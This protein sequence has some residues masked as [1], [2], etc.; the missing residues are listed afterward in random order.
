MSGKRRRGPIRVVGLM[1][2]TSTDGIDAALVTIA[3]GARRRI[4]LVKYA[5]YSYPRTLRT[6][7]LSLTS[8]RPVRLDEL[9]T[10]HVVLGEL[11]AA[12]ALRIIAAAGVARASVA[13]IGSHGQTVCHVPA[14][15]RYGR[16]S[17]RSTLQIA[18]PSVIAERTGITTVADFR[19]RDQAAGGEG[20]P[21]TPHLHN[22]LFRHPS[23]HRV[24]VNIGGI[25][26]VTSLQP[27]RARVP[28]FDAGPGNMLIDGIVRARSRGRLQMDRGGRLAHQGRVCPP[29]LAR[30]LRHPFLSQPSPKTT[31]RETF[32]LAAMQPRFGRYWT[33][34][35]TADLVATAT[36]LTAESIARQCRRFLAGSRRIDEVIVG[37][38]GGRN[39]VL[40]EWLQAAM[41]QSRVQPM[42]AYGYDGRAIEA[43][44]FALLAYETALGRPS[45]LPSATGARRAVVLGKVVPGHGMKIKGTLRG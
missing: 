32:G 24:V 2:G 1:S 11:F 17:I 41:P 43:M 14:P 33:S 29:L 5:T 15:A 7:L 21:L 27:G 35:S 44:A 26:N 31:G 37:G 3:G 30:L 28:A 6:Q 8:G 25:S 36:A 4:R 38:G 9:S 13:L 39:G 16:L 42:E 19:P 40:M 20:A 22:T 10:L 45:N 23:R 34:L 18:E 12:A